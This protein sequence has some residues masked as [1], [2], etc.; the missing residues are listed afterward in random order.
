MKKVLI[1]GSAALIFAVIFYFN[2]ESGVLIG[3]SLIFILSFITERDKT[4]AWI[5]ALIISW[6]WVYAA[7]GRSEEHTS[8]LQS[9]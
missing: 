2:R 9:H 5:P 3:T 6:L 7:K 4:W 1:W 8:E